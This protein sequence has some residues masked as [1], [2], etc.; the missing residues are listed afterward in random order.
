MDS[1]LDSAFQFLVDPKV[2]HITADCLPFVMILTTAPPPSQTRLQ[3]DEMT[4]SCRV[5]ATY[6]TSQNE[7]TRVQYHRT[8]GLFP[9]T[10]RDMIVLF[11]ARKMGTDRVVIVQRSV[12]WDLDKIK[13][14]GEGLRADVNIAGSVIGEFW[15]VAHLLQQTQGSCFDSDL[16]RTSTG[17]QRQTSRPHH[18]CPRRKLSSRC[19]TFPF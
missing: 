9:A 5:L 12:D 6:T 19:P 13:D 10:P 18:P 8:K 3:W 17:S 7:I 1:T 11:H 2:N 4:E 14:E 16:R 15:D